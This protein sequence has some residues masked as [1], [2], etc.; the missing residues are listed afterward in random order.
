MPVKEQRR[1][2]AFSPIII[3]KYASSKSSASPRVSEAA[4]SSS[5]DSMQGSDLAGDLE[6]LEYPY[7][8]MTPGEEEIMRIY[9][10]KVFW[11]PDMIERPG[12]VQI[13][14]F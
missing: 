10:D 2:P 12:G 7:R 6:Q 14:R 1:P 5:D 3:H 9:E 13:Q 8:P 4:L 11:P